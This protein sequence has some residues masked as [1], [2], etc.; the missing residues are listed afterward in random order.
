MGCGASSIT[1]TSITCVAPPV[2]KREHL[3]EITNTSA[4]LLNE[5]DQ[6]AR[7]SSPVLPGPRDV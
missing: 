3:R 2:G 7:R 5:V 6:A 1:I 4:K